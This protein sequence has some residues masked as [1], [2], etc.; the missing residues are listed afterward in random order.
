MISEMA[1]KRAARPAVLSRGRTIA[2]REGRIWGRHISYDGPL[3]HLSAHVDSSSGYEDFYQTRVTL[4]EVADELVDHDCSCPAARRFPGPCKHCVALALD[5]N[6][7]PDAYDGMDGLRHRGTSPAL[8]AYLGRARTQETG[9]QQSS[10]AQAAP[11]GSVWLEPTLA[12]VGRGRL[13]RFRVAGPNGSYVLKSIDAF[14]SAMSA[15]IWVEYGRKLAFTHEPT[16]FTEEARP[17]VAF[18]MRA[19]QNRRSYQAA[20]Y[21][22]TGRGSGYRAVRVGGS[23]SPGRELRLSDPET[24]ELV[25]LLMGHRVAVDAQDVM[26]GLCWEAPRPLSVVE[27]DPALELELTAAGEDGY[28]LTY[29]RDLMFFA[30][31]EQLY[32]VDGQCLWRCSERLRGVSDF[33]TGIVG[34]SGEQWLAKADARTFAA[35]VLPELD[36]RVCITVPPEVDDLRPEPVS[37]AFYLDSTRSGVSVDVV[38]SYGERSWHVLGREVGEA[39]D[40]VRDLRAESAARQLVGRYAPLARIASSTRRAVI[41]Q[42]DA[43]AIA[44]LVFEGTAEFARMGTVYATDAFARLSRTS[45]PRVR[46]GASLRAGL[47]DLSVLAD[48]L[49]QDELYALLASVRKHRRYHRLRDGSFVDVAGLDLSG[50]EGVVDEMGLSAEQLARGHAELPVYKAFLL[51]GMMTDDEKDAS[52]RRFVK[53][54]HAADPTTYTPPATLAPRLRGYQVAGFQ[55]MSALLDMGMGG[56]LA[57]EMG[58]G[59]SV[60]LIALVRARRGEGPI[61]VV[62]PASLVYNWQAEFGKFAP[63]LDVAVVA[64]TAAQRRQ[65]RGE[66]HEVYVTS[67]D[68]FRRDVRG[69]A[70]R[71]LWLVALDEAQCIKN[72]ETLVARA[73]KALDARHRLALTGTPIENRL[74]ELWSIFDFLMPGLLGGYERFRERYEQPIAACDHDAATR[75]R[76]AV[77]PFILR[78]LKADVLADL[79][80]KLEQVVYAQMGAKQGKLYRASEQALRLS[81]TNQDGLG[82]AHDKLQVLAELT[83]LRQI[84]CDPRLVSDDY[85]GG[86]AKLDAIMELV[87]SAMDSG[88]KVLVFSQFTSYLALIA[89]E[90]EEH[91]VAYYTITGSTPKRRRIQLV[92]AFNGDETPVF[93]VSLKAGGTGLNLVGASV[94]IHADPWWNAAAQNQATDRAH[95][96]GQVRD[97]TVYKVIAHDTIEERILALQEAKSDLANQVVGEGGGLSLAS[98]RREDLIELLGE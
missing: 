64:G 81:L 48:D 49:P 77:G 21:L 10:A 42:R 38:A 61:L 43:D 76:R 65:V 79:P 25:D 59:K 56:I 83:R 75:L 87:S 54:F 3:T 16:A 5:Y 6:R 73:V 96:I 95:R 70:E 40:P 15:G 8:G 41:S 94:V 97:V 11:D 82:F 66:R 80:E 50:A 46:V 23:G 88:Q 1:L 72:H 71:P 60:Q 78:R 37:L 12:L 58:L 18:L 62:C 31:A 30:T 13:V 7:R 4:D 9:Y 39:I 29:P 45:T 19:V 32:A 93:L 52:F 86:S 24:D 67:Y 51:D 68:L 91:E 34:A 26:P 74:S 98:L 63:E 84:C 17:L 69:W 89:Q 27:G 85:Q 2:R 28:E 20:S 36:G 35:T 53:D 47:I 90:L 92:D 14:V 57:D 22:G 55:W 33:L 44:R